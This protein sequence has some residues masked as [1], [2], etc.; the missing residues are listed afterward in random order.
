MGTFH[1]EDNK[2]NFNASTIACIRKE[3]EKTQINNLA[4]L[5]A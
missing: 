1:F 3:E 5:K 4:V 2:I